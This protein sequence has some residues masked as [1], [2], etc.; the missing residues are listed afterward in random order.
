MTTPRL[1]SASRLRRAEAL[2]AFALALGG[3]SSSSAA[4]SDAGAS[5]T[6][7]A[8]AAPPDAAPSVPTQTGKVIQYMPCSTTVTGVGGA[9]VAIGS[10]TATTAA[11][12]TYAI[13]VP[14]GTP[15]T[16]TVTAPDY[17][18]LIEA[19]DTVSGSYDRGNTKLI[20]SDTA[21]LL[22][23]ALSNYDADGGLLTIELVKTGTCADLGGTTVQ[24]SPPSANSLTQ[25]PAT[26]GSPVG[27]TGSATDGV[28]PAAVVYNLTPG[29]QTVSATSPK[30]TQIPY[31]YTDPA[32]GLTYDGNV[33][34]QAGTGTSFTRV[35]MK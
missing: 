5:S 3:C 26:C 18:Q 29:T 35:F 11:D 31:P 12:G 30:C 28:F 23:A 24:L 2:A 6:A 17:V 4:P 10:K 9:T 21:S 33:T 22:S 34:T 14:V 32:T 25:Y 13:E 27:T 20:L 19:E 1:P 16:M 8:D 7:P 15:F